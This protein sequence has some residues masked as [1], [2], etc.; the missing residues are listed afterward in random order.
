MSPEFFCDI[1]IGV[2]AFTAG[3]EALLAKEAFSAGDGERYH[4]AI[5][6]LQLPVFRSDFDDFAHALV[7]ENV[8]L[9]HRGHDAVEQME[10]RTAAQ[11]VT[12]LMA[13]RPCSIFGS[14]TLSQRISFLA[15]H[16]SAFISILPAD[17][18]CSD[19]LRNEDQFVSA[20][21]FRRRA[22]CGD[23]IPA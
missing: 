2:G 3:E 23:Y 11:A 6:D 19:K 8:T 14:G 1:V 9:L 18:L 15:C 13:S 12:L 21:N 7:A 4:D 20:P 22:E 10:V 16:V 17:T 5:A